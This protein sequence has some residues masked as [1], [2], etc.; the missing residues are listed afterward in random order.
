MLLDRA[1]ATA[2]PASLPLNKMPVRVCDTQSD[3][4]GHIAITGIPKAMVGSADLT[5]A[6]GRIAGEPFDSIVARATFNGA[7]V[8]IEN[9][10]A[11]LETG[12][13][14]AKGNYNTETHIGDFN[15]TGQ[16]MQLA[17]M[18]ALSGSEALKTPP[19]QPILPRVTGN[20]KGE[21]SGSYVRLR[22]MHTAP[23]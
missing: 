5:F 18:A 1:S 11:R 21:D 14:L 17:H 10:D 2:L 22:L 9:I 20:L 19:A 6:R 23:T 12:H 16:S 15:I 8:T 3:L 7:N 13:L 4:S